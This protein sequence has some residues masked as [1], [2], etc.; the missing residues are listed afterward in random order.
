MNRSIRVALWSALLC[1]ACS[2]SAQ[3]QV[4]HTESQVVEAIR[5]NNLLVEASR[6]GAAAEAERPG[7]VRRPFP[8]AEV[9][10]MPSMIADGSAGVGVMFSQALPWSS[11]LKAERAARTA[12]AAAAN[13]ESQVIE[14]DLI[15][16]GRESYAELWGI[17]ERRARIDSFLTSLEIYQESALAQIQT[18]RGAQQ[19]VLM[20][21]VEAERLEQQLAAI[22]EE[23][24]ELQA[25]IAVL[26]G[27][28]I[29]IGPGDRLA[30]PTSILTRESRGTDEHPALL[31]ADAMREAAREE[32]RS[33]RTRLRPKLSLGAAV[34]PAGSGPDMTE[35]VVPSVGVS[36]PLWT[37][38]IRAQIREAELREQ[39]R[40]IEAEHLQLSLSAEWT[41]LLSQ[42]E[43]V[44]QRIDRFESHLLPLAYQSLEN[45]LLGYRT[46]SRMLIELLDAQRMA[47]DL[48]QDLIDAQVRAT[49]L[50]AR[51]DYL[52]S[53]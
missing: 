46:G 18:G 48:E 38:G 28:T 44:Q 12:M 22:D 53:H 31:A 17:Y 33:N 9:M 49:V 40:A 13:Y 32:I 5:S 19:S 11:G 42:L 4:L 50:V 16:Q 34:Y 2:Y 45:A 26:T 21:R 25:L 23:V 51:I 15:R 10:F 6:T 3:G 39:Q 27:G 35:Y 52:T 36:L 43:R 24:S 37:G 20:L 7:Q 1:V 41:D 29:R 47:L 14:Q 30:E 8:M